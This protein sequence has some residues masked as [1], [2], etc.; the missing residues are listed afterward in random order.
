MNYFRVTRAQEHKQ[1]ELTIDMSASRR[2]NIVT[3]TNFF[4]MDLGTGKKVIRFTLD[5]K[6]FDL[7]DKQVLLGFEFVEANVRKVFETSDLGSPVVIENTRLGRINVNLPNDVIQYSGEVLIHVYILFEDGR[8]LDAGIIVTEFKESWLDGELAEMSDFYVN[9]FEIL[10]NDLEERVNESR[11]RVEELQNELSRVAENISDNDFA[12][13]S[14]LS[15][16]VS[17]VSNPHQVTIGQ[18]PDLEEQLAQRALAD[19]THE[20]SQVLGVEDHVNDM[21]NPHGVTIEQIGAASADILSSGTW[22]PRLAIGD[23][24]IAS[25]VGSTNFGSWRRIGN[26]VFIHGRATHTVTQ[27]QINTAIN[28]AASGAQLRIGGLPFTPTTADND[29]LAH[30]F[31]AIVTGDRLTSAGTSISNRVGIHMTASTVPFLNIWVDNVRTAQF[32]ATAPEGVVTSAVIGTTLLPGT[33]A[34]RFSGTIII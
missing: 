34:F 33:I 18:I 32:A 11:R 30:V 8:S 3:D 9:R 21:D 4:T 5:G 23:V 26:V 19:H 25:T 31:T 28:N 7:T 24:F 29:P 12:T 14:E 2:R 10:A 1:H 13:S 16:H 17:D 15:E 27:A 20:M 6:P 22:T